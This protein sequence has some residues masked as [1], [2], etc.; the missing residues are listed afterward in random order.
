MK[1]VILKGLF[2]ILIYMVWMNLGGTFYESLFVG[3][4]VFFVLLANPLYNPSKK[5]EEQVLEK[6]KINR[7]RLKNI[8]EQTLEEKKTIN[9]S[10]RDK[11]AKSAK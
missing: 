4:F 3:A 8:H 5:I 1:S 2:G 7:E 9:E 10:I 11:R 6:S